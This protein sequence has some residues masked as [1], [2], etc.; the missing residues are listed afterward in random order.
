MR[1]LADHFFWQINYIY[2]PQIELFMKTF[3]TLLLCLL[4]TTFCF[5]Q[6]PDKVLA[7]VRYTYINKADTL[8]NGKFRVQN[9]LLFVGKNASLYT[10][11]DRLNHQL[12]VDQK[13]RTKMMTMVDNGEPKSIKIDESALKSMSATNHLYFIKENKHYLKEIIADQGYQIEENIDPINW[14]ILKDTLSFSGVLCQKAIASFEGKNWV[15]W[16]APSLPFQSG[17][18]QL[19]GLPGLIIEAYDEQ[20]NEHFHFSGLENANGG[21][22]KRFNDVTKRVNSDPD[23]INTIDVMLGF[24]VADA[25]FSNTI[26]PSAI[27]TTNTTKEK[28]EKFKLAMKKTQE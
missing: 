9:M 4:I 14:K 18:W 5:A 13:I 21:D 19:N 10:S 17:P 7:R 20:K 23:F 24:D 26:K 2:L 27:Y 3:L 6:N 15:S 16:F 25:Y 8:K 11:Y 1:L 22:F 28:L 12:A